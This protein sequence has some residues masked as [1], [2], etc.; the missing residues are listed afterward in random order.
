MDSR[1]SVPGTN[2]NIGLDTLIGLVPGIGDTLGMGVSGYIIVQS[3]RLGVPKR[4]IGKMVMNSGID[5]VIG[6]IPL[7]GDLFDWGWK[8]NNKNAA[9]LRNH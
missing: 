4:A 2:L 3:K 6:T 1:F 9:I 7:I 8:A 5:W